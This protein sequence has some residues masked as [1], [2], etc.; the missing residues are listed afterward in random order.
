MLA[1]TEVTATDA[2]GPLIE[3]ALLVMQAASNTRGAAA[4]R[5]AGG[6]SAG[7]ATAQAGPA[8]PV[9]RSKAAPADTSAAKSLALR[10]DL[11]AGGQTAAEGV[12][13]KSGA[14]EGATGKLSSVSQAPSSG[15]RSAGSASCSASTAGDSALFAVLLIMAIHFWQCVLTSCSAIY[16]RCMHG[17]QLQVDL[18][19]CCCAQVLSG[20]R[21]SMAV[22][23]KTIHWRLT[24][25]GPDLPFPDSGC[26]PC[27]AHS[28]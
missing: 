5:R 19:S 14:T 23:T 21:R 28:M 20:P 10:S 22:R 11:S 15:K 13:G 18:R 9:L 4:S 16:V 3:A 12:P 26:Q 17:L 2:F 6:R 1:Y 7:Q 24:A 8:K 27:Q 25:P